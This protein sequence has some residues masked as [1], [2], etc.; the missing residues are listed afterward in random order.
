M[1]FFCII[2]NMK[3]SILILSL[4]SIFTCCKIP[5]S[6]EQIEYINIAEVGD[7]LIFCCDSLNCDTLI[8]SE[9][10]FYDTDQILG[11]NWFYINQNAS[12]NFYHPNNKDYESSLIIIYGKGEPSE[13]S[14]IV[15]MLNS[16]WFLSESYTDLGIAYDKTFVINGEEYSE[17][18]LRVDWDPER[19]N[20]DST[21][22][23][24]LIWNRKIG[25]IEYTDIHNRTWKRIK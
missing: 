19:I 16:H 3:K 18:Y 1:G 14:E 11:G 5:L 6:D 2:L 17:N 12:L 25:P 15:I 10:E 23:L 7:T 4:L 22:L 9:K 24:N 21:D 13:S 8:I 20:P